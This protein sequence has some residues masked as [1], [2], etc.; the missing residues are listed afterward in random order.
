ME[1]KEEDVSTDDEEL[2]IKSAKFNPLKALYSEKFKVPC[3]DAKPLDNV[4]MFMSR[5]KKAGNALDADLEPKKQPLKNKLE[6]KTEDDKFHV[7]AAG[8]RFLKEQGLSGSMNFEV[9]RAHK[10]SS[11]Q[12]QSIAVRKQS[13][14]MI[15]SSEWKVPRDRFRCSKNSKTIG[16]E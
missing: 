16:R 13:S 14:R 8:R 1:P 5:L 11:P 2:D 9:S 3:E 6:Q 12:L 4:A 10:V 7:T 15:S